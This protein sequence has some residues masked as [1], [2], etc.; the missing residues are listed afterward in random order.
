MAVLG[1]AAA[2][3]IGGFLFKSP[4]LHDWHGQQFSAG[5]YND[6]Q[7]LYPQRRHLRAHLPVHPRKLTYNSGGDALVG[8]AFEYPVLT[9]V[10]AWF[11][12]LP[13]HG[14]NHYFVW[15][16][17]LLAPFG[18]LT[19]WLLARMTGWRALY[20]A[21]APSVV[22]YAFHNWDLLVV[23]A[24]VGA[25]YAWWRQRY[26]WAAFLLGVGACLKLYPLFFLRRSSSSGSR[27]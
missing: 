13:I 18:L 2:T 6:I 20:F 22:L 4:C 23:A 11:A 27:E 9:G 21:A 16:A 19:A 26:L 1:I 24:T 3:L 14:A 17:I 12:G 8:G 15:S 7:F 10:F 25:F 5:C